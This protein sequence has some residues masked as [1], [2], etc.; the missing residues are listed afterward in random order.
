VRDLLKTD[1]SK[2]SKLNIL[3]NAINLVDRNKSNFGKI[4]NMSSLE[5]NRIALNLLS[6]LKQ[7]DRFYQDQ[8]SK[9][10]LQNLKQ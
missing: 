4:K 9:A 6:N 10:V 7:N 2:D 3:E 5:K 1:S 8:Q